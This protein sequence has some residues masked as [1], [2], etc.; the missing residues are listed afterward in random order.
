MKASALMFWSILAASLGQS[1]GSSIGGNPFK[2]RYVYFTI[3]GPFYIAEYK[4]RFYPLFREES[5][6]S[7]ATAEDAAEDLS[8]GRA[9]ALPDVD[10]AALRIPRDLKKWQRV[11]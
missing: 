11:A 7:Y 5:L 1:L 6:G 3:Q 2:K 8:Y 10:I 9:L 4:K